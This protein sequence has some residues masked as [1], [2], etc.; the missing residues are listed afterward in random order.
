MLDRII[1]LGTGDRVIDQYPKDVEHIM[2]TQTIYLLTSYEQIVL[3]DL[4]GKSKK[5]I[6]AFVNLSGLSV[7]YSGEGNATSMNI[8]VGTEINSSMTLEVVF[9]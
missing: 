2:N 7:L 6:Q 1:V 9:E 4:L 8:E 5:D 3:P